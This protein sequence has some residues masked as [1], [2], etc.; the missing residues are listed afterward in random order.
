[1]QLS[2]R[3]QRIADF[4]R[5]GDRIIDVGTD[6][7]YIPIWLLLNGIVEHAAATDIRSGPLERARTDAE[8]YGVSDHLLLIQCDGLAQC[9]PQDADTVIISGMGGETI[10]GILADA[11]WTREKRLILQPQTKQTELRSYL[12]SAGYTI[13]DAA[14]VC[15]MGRIYLIWLVKAGEMPRFQG[16]DGPLLTHR[17]PLLKPYLSDRI[18]RIRKQL[19]GLEAAVHQDDAQINALRVLLSQLEG[20]YNEVSTWQA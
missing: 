14:L 18:K 17:D 8:Y 7:A 4:V 1:M 3:L 19:H 20:I 2:K 9:S 10:I 16:V 6:H 15:D 12:A 11:P 13:S 5:P